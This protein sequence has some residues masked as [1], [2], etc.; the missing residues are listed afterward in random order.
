[1]NLEFSDNVIY[2]WKDRFCGLTQKA[3]SGL[4]L[5]FLANYY[6][7]G[8]DTD[9]PVTAFQ[10]QSTGDTLYFANNRMRGSAWSSA[11]E[12][13]GNHGAA[14]KAGSPFM[15][16]FT[17]TG[18]ALTARDRVRAHGGC[19]RSRDTADLAYVNEIPPGTE[20]PKYRVTGTVPATLISSYPSSGTLPGY[21]DSD[22]DGMADAWESQYAIGGGIAKFLPW[23]DDDGD[24]WTNLEEYLNK[25][26]PKVGDDPMK[27]I[28]SNIDGP[29]F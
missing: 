11:Y 20:S 3:S 27:S 2:N 12:F 10:I 13:V 19:S 14:A 25:T 9:D 21:A 18:N 5:Q 17:S 29:L 1:M 16:N 6:K 8:N 23:Q 15:T 22:T 28:Q 4:R 7:P 26:N 24:G